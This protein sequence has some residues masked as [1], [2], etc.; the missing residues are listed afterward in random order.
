MILNILVSAIIIFAVIMFFL[1]AVIVNG[2]TKSPDNVELPEKCSSCTTNCHIRF[3]S[4]PRSK[5]SIIEY[6][7]NCEENNA[8]QEAN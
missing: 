1:L 5:E 7:K 6:Y 8:K 3:D 2:L 4:K